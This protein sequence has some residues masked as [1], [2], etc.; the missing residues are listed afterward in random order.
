MICRFL[1][2]IILHFFSKNIDTSN[3]CPEDKNKTVFS[4]YDENDNNRNDSSTKNITYL[5]VVKMSRK[6]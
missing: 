4:K 2:I 6:V 1:S 5:E 3:Q